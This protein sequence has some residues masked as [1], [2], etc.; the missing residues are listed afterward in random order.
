MNCFVVKIFKYNFQQNL[1][2]GYFKKLGADLVL[3]IKLAEDF[4]LLESQNEFMERFK[5]IK[6][7]N[8]KK[9]LPMLASSCPGIFTI[10]MI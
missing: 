6:T 9:I 8:V 3:D 4:A 2:L 7:S 10:F 5:S 1:F